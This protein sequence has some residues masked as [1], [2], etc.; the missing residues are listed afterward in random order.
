MENIRKESG[1][2]HKSKSLFFQSIDENE[3]LT[4]DIKANL[5]DLVEQ[6]F[7]VIG[8]TIVMAEIFCLKNKKHGI[9]RLQN[10]KDG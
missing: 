7:N 2:W 5:K 3:L 8:K 10:R 1:L 6:Q 4:N 9:Y